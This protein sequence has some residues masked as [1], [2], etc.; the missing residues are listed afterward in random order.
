MTKFE[1]NELLPCNEFYST[2]K[3]HKEY[4]FEQTMI[5]TCIEQKI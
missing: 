3:A 5:E 2:N 1:T 4:Y